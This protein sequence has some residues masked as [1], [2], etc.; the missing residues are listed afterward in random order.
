[1]TAGFIKGLDPGVAGAARQLLLTP[2][3]H[4]Q[5]LR[6]RTP[7]EEQERGAQ[8]K[9]ISQQ[10]TRSRACWESEFCSVGEVE[11]E[12]EDKQSDGETLTFLSFTETFQ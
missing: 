12:V 7:L 3:H 6:G 1:M 4:L 9:V 10:E 8:K 5:Q 2:P 11:V